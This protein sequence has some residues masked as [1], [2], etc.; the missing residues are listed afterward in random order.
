MDRVPGILRRDTGQGEVALD[1]R[2]G[3]IEF[4]LFHLFRVVVPDD[5]WDKPL[6]GGESEVVI[7]VF[8]A[9]DVDLGRQVTVSRCRYEEMDVRRS[10]PVPA[11]LVQQALGGPVGRAPIARGHDGPELVS[12]VRPRL[13]SPSQIVL[14]LAFVEERVHAFRVGVPH[15][16]NGVGDWPAVQVPY[17]PVHEQHLTFVGAVVEPRAA[18]RQGCVGDVERAFDCPRGPLLNPGRLVL[19]VHPQIEKM[20][21]AEAGRQQARFHVLAEIVEVVDGSPEF[22][23]SHIQI[24]DRAEKIG[25]DPMN[26]LFGAG[27]SFL[28]GHSADDIQEFLDVLGLGE[29]GGHGNLPAVRRGSEFSLHPRRSPTDDDRAVSLRFS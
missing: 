10:L 20:L 21:E 11:E 24:F 22:V 4:L 6:A 9:S 28:R 15:I 16:D 2:E 7:E 1:F 25:D 23:G 14:A 3:R 18:F 5:R 12:A 27:V 29:L 17:D 19:G 13:D 8:V 26:D